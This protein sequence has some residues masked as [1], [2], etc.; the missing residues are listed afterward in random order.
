MGG[1]FIRGSTL[2]FALTGCAFGNNAIVKDLCLGAVIGVI[3][4]LM[5]NKLLTLAVP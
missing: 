1:G 4:F 5:F 2:L 3:I